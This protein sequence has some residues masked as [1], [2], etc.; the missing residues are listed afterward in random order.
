MTAI[1]KNIEKKLTLLNG[2]F[3]KIFKGQFL[4]VQFTFQSQMISSKSDIVFEM[5]SRCIPQ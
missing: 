5:R 4:S 2:Q 3:F 1:I